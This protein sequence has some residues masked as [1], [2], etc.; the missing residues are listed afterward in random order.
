MVLFVRFNAKEKGCAK[1]I[2]SRGGGDQQRKMP[3]FDIIKFNLR[4]SST[5]TY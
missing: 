4:N 3:S 2:Y 1:S 5:P